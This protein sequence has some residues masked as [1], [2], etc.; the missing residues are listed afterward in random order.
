M[1]PAADRVAEH[2]EQ[3]QDGADHD[4][5][6]SGIDDPQLDADLKAL[7]AMA[8]RFAGSYKGK[9]AERLSASIGDYS[10]IEMLQEQSH[11]IYPCARAR[12]A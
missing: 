8:K 7:E 4:I 3:G 10:E 9:L 11:R 2:P 1:P 5:L 6:Y 12:T